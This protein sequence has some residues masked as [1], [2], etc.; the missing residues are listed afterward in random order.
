VI[1]QCIPQMT[2][3]ESTVLGLAALIGTSQTGG[4]RHC[5]R[6]P[7]LSVNRNNARKTK[8]RTL[9]I[10]PAATATP[11]KPRTEATRAVT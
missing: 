9:A 10:M 4:E 8:N 2:G 3:V 1:F 6:N 11:P 5:L 7:A